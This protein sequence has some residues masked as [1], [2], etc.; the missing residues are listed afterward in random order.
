MLKPGSAKRPDYGER[1]L[2]SVRGL[3]IKFRLQVRP[4]AMEVDNPSICDES[5]LCAV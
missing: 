2:S 5:F 1:L 4:K 3:L